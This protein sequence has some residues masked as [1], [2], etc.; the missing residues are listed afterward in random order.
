M[1][2][3]LI[4][5]TALFFFINL[6]QQVSGKVKAEKKPAETER[7]PIAE[8]LKE[9]KAARRLD[10]KSAVSNSNPEDGVV[11]RYMAMTCL[12]IMAVGG[13][14]AFKDDIMNLDMTP[15]EVLEARRKRL[16]AHRKQLK[17][18]NE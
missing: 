7:I 4:I 10:K 12:L 2:V 15:P 6:S 8:V 18:K 17:S 13:F 14:I 5:I 9:A 3:S 16:E 1:K 11:V